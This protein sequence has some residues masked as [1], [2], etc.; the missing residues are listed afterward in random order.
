MSLVE[1]LV[2]GCPLICYDIKYGPRDMIVNGE[3]GFLVQPNDI[4]DL[5]NKIIELMSNQDKLAEFS[6]NSR[7]KAKEFS[8]EK[9][10]ANWLNMF[11]EIIDKKENFINIDGY[12]FYMEQSKWI[13]SENLEYYIE[14]T[15]NIKPETSKN[16]ITKLKAKVILRERE[17]KEIVELHNSVQ[18]TDQGKARILVSMDALI[19]QG[20][21]TKGIWDLNLILFGN[22]Y[23]QEKRIGYDK[24]RSAIT[25][26]K[27]LQDKKREIIIEPYYTN[28]YGNISFKIGG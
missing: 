17:S 4:M 15:V 14:G 18:I 24:S 10:I 26:L 25:D 22:N 7:I 11:S 20:T 19:G 3:N 28:P 1:S 13:S 2:H 12:D 8:N 6:L 21:L 9:F 5:A 27:T 16:D 23:Y